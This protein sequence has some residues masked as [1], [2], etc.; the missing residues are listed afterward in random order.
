VGGGYQRGAF[1]MYDWAAGE[2]YEDQ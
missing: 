1:D 2:L